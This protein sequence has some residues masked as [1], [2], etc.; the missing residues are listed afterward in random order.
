MHSHKYPKNRINYTYR[1]RN[2]MYYT[3]SKLVT[4]ELQY[5][6][7]NQKKL[8]I[9]RYNFTGAGVQSAQTFFPG[10]GPQASKTNSCYLG[11]LTKYQ[12][13]YPDSLK[14]G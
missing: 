8:N 1:K 12:W 11:S 3:H 13:C 5:T 10:S 2:G 14:S 6:V 7:A 9:Y 4:S